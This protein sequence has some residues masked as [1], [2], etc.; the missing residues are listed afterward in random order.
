MA[1]AKLPFLQLEEAL[2]A[3]RF[4][5][6]NEPVTIPDKVAVVLPTQGKEPFF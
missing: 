4:L 1:S 2:V 3:S 6:R 5:C